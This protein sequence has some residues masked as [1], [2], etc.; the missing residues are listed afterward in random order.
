[1]LV[2]AGNYAVLPPLLTVHCSFEGAWTKVVHLFQRLCWPVTAGEGYDMTAQ[3]ADASSHSPHIA[4][5]KT[6]FLMQTWIHGG[7]RA[8]W[9]L[10]PSVPADVAQQ[11]RSSTGV[12]GARGGMVGAS[13]EAYL[14]L[15]WTFCRRDGSLYSGW[16]WTSWLASHGESYGKSPGRL[17]ACLKK[18]V[19]QISFHTLLNR[20]RGN[21]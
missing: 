20:S 7:R 6:S 9:T 12:E 16:R 11:W 18:R 8:T 10:L 2:G 17:C 1:M 21:E 13:E 14:H 19:T 4:W 5:R 3:Q 15:A